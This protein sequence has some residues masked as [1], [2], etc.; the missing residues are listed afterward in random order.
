MT[1]IDP[2]TGLPRLDDRDGPALPFSPEASQRFVMATLRAHEAKRRAAARWPWQVAAGFALLLGASAGS[3]AF[4]I[5]QDEPKLAQNQHT[6][7]HATPARAE[8]PIVETPPSEPSPSESP[9]TPAPPSPPRRTSSTFDLLARANHLRSQ[10]HWRAAAKIYVQA[11]RAAPGS[12]EAYA[13]TVAAGVLYREKLHNARGAVTLFRKAIDTRPDGS[14]S[15][16][17]RWGLA[18]SYRQLN[19]RPAEDKALHL[20]LQHHPNSVLAAQATSRLQNLAP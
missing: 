13:A 5:R 14:L 15:E 6:V 7:V 9:S 3:A 18:L 17:A 4:L 20:F 1:S 10:G 19:M 12:S 8:V 2:Q 16:E 11:S